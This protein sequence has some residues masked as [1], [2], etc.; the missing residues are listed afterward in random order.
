MSDQHTSG[1]INETAVE[2]TPSRAEVATR[3]RMLL[4][5][6]GKGSA[7]LAAVTPI[8]TLASTNSLT[9]NGLICTVSGVGS[10]AHS[11]STT[12][13]T[14]GGLSPGYYKTPSHWP[15]YNATKN[16]ASNTVTKPNGTTCTFRQNFNTAPN[17]LN[18][19]GADDTSFATVFGGGS[20]AGMFYILKNQA[21]TDEFHWIAALLNAV[22]Y[23]TT[24][25]WPKSPYV[26]PYTPTEVLSLYSTDYAAGLAFFKGYMETL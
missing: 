15:G 8:T 4:Q 13:P 11:K 1:A 25:S 18:P 17:G 19:G 9:A 3:R 26:F 23:A 21:P 20:T 7:V 24:G 12:L 5:S 6:V 10:A 16:K 2:E 22:M 14:C